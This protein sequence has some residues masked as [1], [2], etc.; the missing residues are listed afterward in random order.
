MEVKSIFDAE[1]QAIAGAIA[2]LNMDLSSS[3]TSPEVEENRDMFEIA[4]DSNSEDEA[5][6]VAELRSFS[7][8]QAD[9]QTSYE[10]AHACVEDVVSAV[11]VKDFP[12]NDEI[13]S[14]KCVNDEVLSD[15][16]SIVSDSLS[17]I[18]S[19]STVEVRSF[20]RKS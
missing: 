6:N 13:D 1:L 20:T 2:D 15:V 12:S 10:I 11:A 14:N 19:M 8:T 9:Y 4:P 3:S 17:T 5:D 16:D 7:A 18:T